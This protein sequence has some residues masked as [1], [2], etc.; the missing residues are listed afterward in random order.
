MIKAEAMN[1]RPVFPAFGVDFEWGG[2][3]RLTFGLVLGAIG[4]GWDLRVEVSS[5]QGFVAVVAWFRRFD[6]S[7]W[8][9]IVCRLR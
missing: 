3:C 9:G 5:A 8:G 1:G 4:P 6:F 7:A 2:A